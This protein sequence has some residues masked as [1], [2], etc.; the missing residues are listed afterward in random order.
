[1]ISLKTKDR[2]LIGLIGFLTGCHSLPPLKI[3]FFAFMEE[4]V[5]RYRLWPTSKILRDHCK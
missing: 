3:E 2:S 4:L 5:L 1:M